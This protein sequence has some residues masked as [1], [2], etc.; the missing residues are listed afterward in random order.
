MVRT[1]VWW[2]VAASSAILSIFFLFVGISLC[3]AAYDLEHPYQFILTFF[4]SNLI[5]L[6]SVVILLGAVLRMIG[7]LRQGQ[8]SA[9][10]DSLRLPPDSSQERDLRSR[11]PHDQP[12]S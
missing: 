4:S 10:A 11:N 6:I 5:I 8:A 2:T 7:R 1:L 12:N 3:R 9:T